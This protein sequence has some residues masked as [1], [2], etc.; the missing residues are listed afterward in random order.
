MFQFLQLIMSNEL[1]NR[2]LK[3]FRS[4]SLFSS[5]FRYTSNSFFSNAYSVSNSLQQSQSDTILFRQ[6][7]NITSSKC[8]RIQNDKYVIYDRFY[9]DEFVQ[10]WNQI[11]W[12]LRSSQKER[13]HVKSSWDNI[14]NRK[15]H[16]WNHFFEIANIDIEKFSMQYKICHKFLTHFT[17]RN[18]NSNNLKWHLNRIDNCKSLL[19][20]NQSTLNLTFSIWRHSHASFTRSHASD[21]SRNTIDLFRTDFFWC[22]NKFHCRLQCFNSTCWKTIFRRF[23]SSFALKCKYI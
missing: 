4:I 10:W 5:F 16:C 12:V 18:Q 7:L 22:H 17:S 20:F 9:H 2:E 15:N 6:L 11:S 13:D 8:S 3:L 14:K 19:D 1:K 23:A 21:T